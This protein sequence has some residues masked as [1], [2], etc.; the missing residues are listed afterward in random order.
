MSIYDLSSTLK[1]LTFPKTVTPHFWRYDASKVALTPEMWCRP[2]CLISDSVYSILTKQ[3]ND[4]QNSV[5][6]NMIVNRNSI[7]L[8]EQRKS[9]DEQNQ[10]SEP[11]I[12]T[13][14]PADRGGY[15]NSSKSQDNLTDVQI[16]SPVLKISKRE[17]QSNSK[18][19]SNTYSQMDVSN[20]PPPAKSSQTN[21]IQNRGIGVQT[22]SIPSKISVSHPSDT[23]AK[24]TGAPPHLIKR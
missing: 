23:Q 20:N 15:D 4:S 14:L 19:S 17:N 2:D 11:N 10:Y 18:H 3:N 13:S 6:E 12:E 7:S 16:S 22:S 21:V 24:M 5:N 9:L 1:N 8:P